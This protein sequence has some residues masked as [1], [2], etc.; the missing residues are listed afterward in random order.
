MVCKVRIY[1]RLSVIK[2][3]L[4]AHFERQVPVG[5]DIEEIRSGHEIETRKSEPLRLQIFRQC[6]LTNGELSLQ[7]LETFK[8]AWLIGGVQN[9]RVVD[10]LL[11]Q[12]L[13]CRGHHGYCA[14]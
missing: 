12:G 10:H 5:Q 1:K 3:N 4:L 2:L 14:R 9:V 13:G 8:Q 11:H 6:L 7:F